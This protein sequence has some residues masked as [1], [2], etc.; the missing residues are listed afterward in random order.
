VKL[1]ADLPRLA[2]LR[3]GMRQRMRSSPIMNAARLTSELE[4]AYRGMWGKWCEGKQVA[5]R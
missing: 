3:V 5:V 4:R 1:A 2:E